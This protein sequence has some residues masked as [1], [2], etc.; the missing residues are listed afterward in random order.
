LIWKVF[1]SMEQC[2]APDKLMYEVTIDPR[3]PEETP[4]SQI[5]QQLNRFS[6]EEMA[7]GTLDVLGE[8]TF[9][10]GKVRKVLGEL[11][12]AP[13]NGLINIVRK[14]LDDDS[15]SKQ[16]VKLSLIRIWR[17]FGVGTVPE[18]VHNHSI[19]PVDP[20]TASTTSNIKITQ[21]VRK[22]QKKTDT[23]KDYQ[24]SMHTQG[25]PQETLELFR[26]IERFC[27][28]LSPDAVNKF[29]FAKCIAYKFRKNS[30]C[31]LHILKNGLRIWLNLQYS[32]LDNP[33][34]F[35]RDVSN[36]GH[37][38]SGDVELRVTDLG[39]VEMAK[40]LILQSFETVHQR[41]GST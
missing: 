14:Q 5:A 25:K 17:E 16:Q 19:P 9:T 15:L 27:I 8:K 12:L 6:R 13:P 29:I 26:S 31:S 18:T 40:T 4:V 20:E 21:E 1:R 34:P 24:E 23:R 10:D 2:P 35:A 32:R 33:P 7:K 36:V 41:Y 22:P 39:Q 37:W 3:D 38:G 28:A 11:M 30:F